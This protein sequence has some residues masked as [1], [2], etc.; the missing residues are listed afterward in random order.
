M[1]HTKLGGN[2]TILLAGP[3]VVMQDGGGNVIGEVHQRWH[4][5][6]RNYDLYIGKCG[7]RV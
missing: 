5:W 4:L 7:G 2:Y 3:L 1:C 6:Q